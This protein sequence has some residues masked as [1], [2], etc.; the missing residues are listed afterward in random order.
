MSPRVAIELDDSSHARE[1][2]QAR[3]AFV[4]QV[5]QAAGVPLLRFPVQHAYNVSEVRSSLSAFF[6]GDAVPP[7]L[8]VPVDTISAPVCPKCGIP[9]IIR[10]SSRGKFYGCVNYPKCR[11]TVRV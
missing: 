4:E 1:D 10:S 9:L 5:F 8:P 7:P 2:R 3:D 6:A 11:Q